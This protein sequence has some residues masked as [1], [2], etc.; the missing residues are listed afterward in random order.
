VS[1]FARPGYESEHNRVYWAGGD[2][3]GVGPAAHSFLNGLRYHNETSLPDWLRAMTRRPTPSR[4]PDRVD[5]GQMKLE[6]LMLGLRTAEGLPLDEL[7]TDPGV[8][9]ELIAQGLASSSGGR[10]RLSD[11]GFLLLDEIVMRLQ[12]ESD[13]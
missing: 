9:R 6:R 4:I 13:T 1:N 10:L 8:A 2:Y 7:R 5:A 3:L 11:R 12:P